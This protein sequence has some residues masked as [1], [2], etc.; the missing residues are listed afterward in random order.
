MLDS[1]YLGL[2]CCPEDGVTGALQS[3]ACVYK[4]S[5]SLW[6]G[7]ILVRNGPV[8]PRY[9]FVCGYLVPFM[10]QIRHL[11]PHPNPLGPIGQV[12]AGTWPCIGTGGCQAT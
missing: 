2:D 4:K 9:P 11:D 1:M 7:E 5:E 6:E 12:F 3:G 8:A 10:A